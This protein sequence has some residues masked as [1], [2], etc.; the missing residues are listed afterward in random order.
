MNVSGAP[1][2]S[3]QDKKDLVWRY[4][5]TNDRFGAAFA[6]IAA[7]R[8]YKRPATMAFN[9]ASGIGNTEGFRKAWEKRGGKVVASVVYEPNRPSYRSELQSVLAEKPDVIVTGSYLPDTTIII[10]EWYQSGEKNAWI[11]PG[12]AANPQL[13]K[14]LGAEACEGII[15]VDTVSAE[16][17]A[18][19]KHFDAMYTKAMGASATTNVYAPMAYDMMIVLALAMEAAGAGATVAQINSKIRD[20]ANPPGTPVSTFAEGKAA[21]SKKQ[22][23]NYEGASSKLDF[24]QYGDVSPDFGVYVI[25]KGQLVRRDVVS[26][27]ADYRP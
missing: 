10:R 12:W 18:A 15:S 2:I 19:F 17:S 26:I 1:A 3:T 14:A 5:A 16:N 20:I 24:D 23:I 21:L 9:N 8:G 4:Q 25:E 13:V 11:I 27:P 6:E 22:K 7:K